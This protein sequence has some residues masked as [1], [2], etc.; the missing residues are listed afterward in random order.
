MRSLRVAVALIIAALSVGVSS[1]VAGGGGIGAPGPG[2]SNPSDAPGGEAGGGGVA[3]SGGLGSEDYRFPLDVDYTWGDGFGAGRNHE[4]QDIF[5]RCASPILATRAGR[6]QRVDFDPS[7]GNYVVI[8]G[9]GTKV[10]TMYGHML[11][12]SALRRR[13]FVAAGEE[14]GQVGRSGNAS[15]CHLHFEIWTAP[16]WYEGGHPMP[17]VGQLLR[18]WAAKG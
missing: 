10:D 17:N 18:S 9:N 14:I 2:E 4:G 16:G 11:R 7:A 5:A 13:A 1:A 3:P 15:G 12:R 6:V 8:D